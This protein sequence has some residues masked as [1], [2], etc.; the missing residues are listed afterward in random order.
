MKK[1]SNRPDL[2]RPRQ[3][4][5]R[6]AHWLAGQSDTEPKGY[7]RSSTVRLDGDRWWGVVSFAGLGTSGSKP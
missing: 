2:A 5:A 3:I 1:K 7:Q 4:W 6:P